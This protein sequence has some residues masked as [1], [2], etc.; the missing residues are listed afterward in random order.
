[1][2]NFI[3]E[4]T[5]DTKILLLIPLDHRNIFQAHWANLKATDLAFKLVDRWPSITCVM[6]QL[7]M[8][9]RR[10]LDDVDIYVCAMS[11]HES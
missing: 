7:E 11:H 4:H 3:I 8:Q 10:S 6:L 1:M 9:V 5:T 2:N